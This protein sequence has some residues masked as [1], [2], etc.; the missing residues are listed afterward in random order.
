MKN[1][2]PKVPVVKSKEAKNPFYG[3]VKLKVDS[4]KPKKKKK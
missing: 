1:K 2:K 3:V 4:K